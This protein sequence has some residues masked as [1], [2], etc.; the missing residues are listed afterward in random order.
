MTRSKEPV[1]DEILV[2]PKINKM[3]ENSKKILNTTQTP[4]KFNPENTK[5]IN[6]VVNKPIMVVI[7]KT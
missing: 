5:E 4:P 6:P 2:L 1:V 3:R 7:N